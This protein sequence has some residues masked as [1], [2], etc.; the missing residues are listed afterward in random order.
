MVKNTPYTRR[1]FFGRE[2]F[3]VKSIFEEIF[4]N[5]ILKLTVND[6]KKFLDYEKY[7]EFLGYIWS[8]FRLWEKPE[9]FQL[10]NPLGEKLIDYVL[11]MKNDYHIMSFFMI[12]VPENYKH[13]QKPLHCMMLKDALCYN[14][15]EINRDYSNCMIEYHLELINK[16]YKLDD[17]NCNNLM[18]ILEEV[19]QYCPDRLGK[20]EYF[21][22]LLEKTLRKEPE[23]YDKKNELKRPT[24]HFYIGLFMI[25][26]GYYVEYSESKHIAYPEELSNN[27]TSKYSSSQVYNLKLEHKSIETNLK[28]N[29]DTKFN[30]FLH[31]LSL[32]IQ[33]KE[34]EFLNDFPEYLEELET[35]Y[36]EIY[37]LPSDYDRS[38][39]HVDN[40]NI[41]NYYE[42]YSTHFCFILAYA[43]IKT[44]QKAILEKIFEYINFLTLC[45]EFPPNMIPTQ[46]HN[47]AVSLFLDNKYELGRQNLPK[48]WIS[49]NVLKDF[50]DSRISCQD[51]VYKI[52][53]KFMLPYYNHEDKPNTKDDDPTMMN[54]DHE[55]MEY[56][57]NDHNL[58]SLVTHP[59]MEMI[60][61]TKIQKYD[62]I[63]FW[64]LIGFFMFY[65]LPTIGLV[66]I[67]HSNG[68]SSTNSTESVET[69][70]VSQFDGG[71]NGTMDSMDTTQQFNFIWIYVFSAV[72]FLFLVP[73]EIM[74]YF[75]IYGHDYFKKTSNWV[76]ILLVI[77]QS[78]HIVIFIVYQQFPLELLYFFLIFFEGLNVFF[79]IIASLSLYPSLKFSI[80]MKC[81]QTAFSSYMRVFFLFVPLFLGCASLAFI[82]FDKSI[83]GQ[84]EEFH[85]FGNAS[86]KYI[87]MYSGELDISS[88]KITGVIQGAV[89]TLIIILII[90]KTNLILSI[91][92]ND[93]SNIMEDAKI[94]SL[95]L[96]AKKYVEFAKKMRNFYA[97]KIINPRPNN[98]QP[99]AMD[100]LIFK[101]I[102][103]FICKY[104]H[105][106]Q[107]RTLLVEKKSGQVYID[108]R[109]P[110][111]ESTAF[112][113]NW[114]RK[115]ANPFLKFIIKRWDTAFSHL[116]LD[117][118]TMNSI[119]KIMEKRDEEAKKSELMSQIVMDS[120]AMDGTKKAME[121]SSKRVKHLKNLSI[122][123][124]DLNGQNLI[125]R[126]VQRHRPSKT[127]KKIDNLPLFKSYTL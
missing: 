67:F 1:L 86:M 23:V 56:I 96:F 46:I 25:Y 50:L 116:V 123:L 72:R 117:S 20:N 109:R 5:P 27:G 101:F 31:L 33:E 95:K 74:Q 16:D 35:S 127:T 51:D 60:I 3:D 7:A 90:N 124:G 66:Y 91:A 65:I 63:F 11:Q 119:K 62:R 41:F 108:E 88:D 100:R 93:I 112:I 10:E 73:R 26:W 121:K 39:Q 17:D 70:T 44:N 61:M 64:N 69:T 13:V 36:K 84:I 122:L 55:T 57:I 94:F 37:N 29:M 24:E 87:M 9:I 125:K 71:F 102:K 120:E 89:L 32:I 118:D 82:L 12:K 53:C 22:E 45:P 21:Q 98:K 8:E 30:P 43:A 14:D 68:N 92:V 104:P 85:S 111:F 81:F 58:E 97:V 115:S 2:T 79:M 76:E 6:T 28:F 110:I 18:Y 106:H 52:D 49:E 75:Y 113:P 38:H 80:Y 114:A 42:K 107:I 103:L 78:I 105:L 4:L 34:N 47:D 15:D 54:E 19:H 77:I 126:K 83:G 40:E 99:N 59:V 48:S